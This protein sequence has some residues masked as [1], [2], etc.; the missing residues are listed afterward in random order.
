MYIIYICFR[1]NYFKILSIIPSAIQ[2][3]LVFIYFVYN[4]VFILNT[5]F[6]PCPFPLCSPPLFYV[7][8]ACWPQMFWG[9]DCKP[10][11]IPEE[12]WQL[13]WFAIE[14]WSGM[15]MLMHIQQQNCR[16][17]IWESVLFSW[18]LKSF[19]GMLYSLLFHFFLSFL[20]CRRP[21]WLPRYTCYW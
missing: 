11:S 19:S 18:T 1:S 8:E 6:I 9:S 20:N 17:K 21:V 2:Q 14:R 4:S 13:A 7:C 3:V 10:R 12:W 5:L 15:A 16:C